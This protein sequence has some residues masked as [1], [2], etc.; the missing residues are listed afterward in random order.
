MRISRDSVTLSQG[1]G[2]GRRTRF[3]R[4]RV[5]AR[6]GSNLSPG[7]RCWYGG[8]VVVK[9]GPKLQTLKFCK[10]CGFKR[11]REDF[12]YGGQVRHLCRKHYDEQRRQ[13]NEEHRE[14]RRAYARA[15]KAK[16][17]EE[18]RIAMEAARESVRQ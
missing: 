4:E 16:L 10:E 2:I 12:V 1:G 6:E 14:E 5:K 8:N 9:R 3:K 7:I 15:Y 13:Y 17:K 18:D 11:P